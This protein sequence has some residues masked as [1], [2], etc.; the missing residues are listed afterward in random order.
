MIGC[1]HAG[2]REHMLSRQDSSAAA[3][4]IARDSEDSRNALEV[5]PWDEGSAAVKQQPAAV[6]PAAEEA[7]TGEEATSLYA[8]AAS[9]SGQ[10][11]A[12]LAGEISVSE[13]ISPALRN[14][15]P[16]VVTDLRLKPET[17]LEGDPE[18][19]LER[20]AGD[21]L[22]SFRESQQQAAADFQ[23]QIRQSQTAVKSGVAGK[24]A[25]PKA[26]KPKLKKQ[27][28]STV[29][30]EVSD[31][32]MGTARRRS[33]EQRLTDGAGA[34]DASPRKRLGDGLLPRGSASKGSAAL[35][36]SS[37]DALTAAAAATAV[38]PVE[39]LAEAAGGSKALGS[40]SSS[41]A[42]D[43]KDAS[44]AS[45]GQHSG[46]GRSDADGGGLGPALDGGSGVEGSADAPVAGPKDS[47]QRQ[48]GE[49][50]RLMR[51]SAM[52]SPAWCARPHMLRLLLLTHCLPET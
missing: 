16:V 7:G 13:I 51:E 21:P 42:A 15:A 44:T 11:G 52:V 14:A 38:D 45:G 40:R 43:G 2:A 27:V 6:P 26:R 29:G 20:E 3:A 30:D 34:S 28:V 10:R 31:M 47:L 5:A 1:C 25:Q 18:G 22:G 23:A 36:V 35:T 17:D 9:K 19:D 46:R 33:G 41:T 37:V 8:Q 49:R 32:Y 4:A 50:G 12:E 48:T 24:K 39:G